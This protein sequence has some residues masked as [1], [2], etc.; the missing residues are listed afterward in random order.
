MTSTVLPPNLSL[1]TVKVGQAPLPIGSLGAAILFWGEESL[2]I[3][4]W[5][6]FSPENGPGHEFTSIAVAHASLSQ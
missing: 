4:T 3:G 2:R 5:L 6:A 1:G